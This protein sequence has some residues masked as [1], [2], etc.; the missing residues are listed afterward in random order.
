VAAFL[1]LCGEEAHWNFEAAGAGWL[2]L[3]TP[4]VNLKA[5]CTG[6]A[7]HNVEVAPAVV[8]G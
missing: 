6:D 2:R 5:E 8:W 7:G 4:L 3:I 1:R